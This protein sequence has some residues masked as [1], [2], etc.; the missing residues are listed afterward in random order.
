MSGTASSIVLGFLLST[1]YGTLFHVLIG[2][3]ARR[4]ILY[5]IAA[6]LGF[7]IGHF[8]GDILLIDWFRLGPLNLLSASVGSWIALFASWWLAGRAN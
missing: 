2:G 1:A 4:L 6:W 8:L 5:L 3:P 7:A